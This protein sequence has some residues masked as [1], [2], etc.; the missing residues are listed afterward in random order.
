LVVADKS[1]RV[2]RFQQATVSSATQIMASMGVRHPDELRPHMLRRRVDP[3]TVTSYA[4][5]YCW[6]DQRELL[7]DPPQGWAADW[8]A[9]DPDRFT[10]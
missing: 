3:H 2:Q 1:L 8:S 4:D 9:A 6:L 7:S 5:L 10:I